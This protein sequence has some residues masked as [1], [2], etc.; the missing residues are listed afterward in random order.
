MPPLNHVRHERFAQEV[1]LGKTGAAAWQ[2]ASGK[3]SV[4]YASAVG[5]RSD[6]SAR[7]AELKA[8]QQALHKKAALDAA[9]RFE[10]TIE[11]IAGELARIAFANLADYVKFGPDGVPRTDFSTLTFDQSAALQVLTIEEIKAKTKDGRDVRRMRFKLG[12]K[13]LA[14]VALGRHLGMFNEPAAPVEQR[15]PPLVDRLATPEEWEA[16]ISRQGS[17]DRGAVD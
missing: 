7:L 13:R 6:V 17:D 11:R 14:L 12:D 4:A 10:V 16:E 5:K 9:A 8:E 1:A 15:Q 2:I 3:R